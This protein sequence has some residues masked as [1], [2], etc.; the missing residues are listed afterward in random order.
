MVSREAGRAGL[1]FSPLTQRPYVRKIL[2]DHE[3][4]RTALAD[5][6]PGTAV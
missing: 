3:T 6:L 1:I 2:R 4:G 5:A